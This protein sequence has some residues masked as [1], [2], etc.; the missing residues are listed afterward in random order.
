MSDHRCSVGCLTACSYYFARLME[1]NGAAREENARLKSWKKHHET[2]TMTHPA[3]TQILLDI[4]ERKLEEHP[5]SPLAAILGDLMTEVDALRTTLETERF[6]ARALRDGE[7]AEAPARH[8]THPTCEPGYACSA[9]EPAAP[10]RQKKWEAMGGYAPLPN[11]YLAGEP[12][13]AP[14]QREACETCGHAKDD[15]AASEGVC[16]IGQNGVGMCGCARYAE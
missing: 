7:A 4:A 2:W 14:P 1:E 11:G 5:D 8:C 16:L 13:A 6:E 9:D 3:A 10:E 15:H 12:A